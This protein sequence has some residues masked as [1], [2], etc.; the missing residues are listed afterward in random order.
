MLFTLLEEGRDE[1]RF[2]YE[3]C[4]AEP[5]DLL[6]SRLPIERVDERPESFKRAVPGNSS[7]LEDW[8]PETLLTCSLTLISESEEVT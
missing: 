7:S 8:Y 6:P 2:S 5:E 1:L 3:R 4:F